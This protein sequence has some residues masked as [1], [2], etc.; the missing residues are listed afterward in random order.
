MEPRQRLTFAGIAALIAVV[1]VVLLVAA[2]GSDD[3]QP[4]ASAQ[5]PTTDTGSE[6]TPAPTQAPGGAE[7]EAEPGDATA[8]P[9]ATARP[10]PSIPVVRVRGGEPV[11]GVKEIEVQQG[12]RLRFRVVA[13]AGDEVH[14]HGY[15]VER[16]VGPGQDARFNV[17]ATITGIFEAELHG[18]GEPIARIRVDP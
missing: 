7:A 13:D 6:T 5:N 15:D 11:G 2:G 10:R 17:K 3:D 14:L 1:A 4:P 18:S 9:T 16:P 8:T 12:Q